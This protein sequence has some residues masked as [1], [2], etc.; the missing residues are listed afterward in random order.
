MENEYLITNQLGGYS[1][2]D[3][4]L[5]N[6]R[7]YHGLLIVSDT[8]LKRKVVV[9]G[10]NECVEIEGKKH[11]LNTFNFRHGI[12]DPEG[13]NNIT[14]THIGSEEVDIEYEIEDIKIIKE[15]NIEQ[16]QNSVIV[17]YTINSPR[18]IDF[19]ISPLI[20]DRSIHGLKSY[21]SD[22]EFEIKK[23]LNNLDIT[24]S[25]QE[26]LSVKV[27]SFNT[28]NLLNVNYYIDTKQVVYNNFEY[29][30]EIERG[31][32]SLEDQV[33]VGNIYFEIDKGENYITLQFSY[34]HSAQVPPGKLSN[35]LKPVQNRVF[36]VKR[37]IPELREF[38]DFLAVRSNDFLVDYNYKKTIIA[39]FH[40]FSD[41]GRDTFISFRG[42]LLVN[43]KY[44]FAKKLL[45]YWTQHIKHGLIPNELSSKTY[46]SIDASLWFI[47][48]VFYYYEATK[49]LDTM[50]SLADEINHIISEF[51]E[52]T[53]Y[54]IHVNSKGYL[55]WD[56]KSVSLSWMDS[57]IEGGSA[58]GRKGYLIEIE[59]LWYNALKILEYFDKEL[60]LTCLSPKIKTM[61]K[62][63]HRS[64]NTDFWSSTLKYSYDYISNSEK[65]DSIRPNVVIGLS[66]P[67][68]VF[69]TQRAKDIFKTVES[70]LLHEMGLHSLSPKDKKYRREYKGDLMER[71][72]AY[73]NGA[74]WPFLLGFYFKAQYAYLGKSSVPD[75]K[76]GLKQ[77]YSILLKKNL[78]YIPEIFDPS[79]SHP[80][81]AISQAWNYALFL[82]VLNDIGL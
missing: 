56:D 30:V 80:D 25:P 13:L 28:K 19:I 35:S 32:E 46:N 79:D 41:W 51:I 20:T 64:I 60:N 15:I 10:L 24:L 11:Y 58:T 77:Y 9:G 63:L 49:D 68:K 4:K 81:G 3:L 26:S 39:G 33:R 66:L 42:L 17:R 78:N 34:D 1:A 67:F 12:S 74:V 57:N 18:K 75:I 22:F 6:T 36:E 72:K 7:K 45:L 16:E 76:K 82:E 70:E 21:N 40:W 5:G 43:K 44:N 27:L 47:I 69:N 52:G 71:D 53:D 14:A 29:P 23:Y 73:H 31:L 54:K 61:I 38:K 48:A 55:T 59:L 2:S 62:T 37:N 50:M 8:E 65:D